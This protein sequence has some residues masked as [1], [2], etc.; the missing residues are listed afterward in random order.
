MFQEQSPSDIKGGCGNWDV[1]PVAHPSGHGYPPELC[2]PQEGVVASGLCFTPHA[3]CP[4][5]HIPMTVD[6][7]L[8]GEYYY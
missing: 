7:R 4:L 1:D 6:P 8:N 2:I 5:F 3:S